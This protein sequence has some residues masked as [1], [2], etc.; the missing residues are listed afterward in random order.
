MASWLVTHA[1]R[2]FDALAVPPEFITQFTAV[3]CNANP[4]HLLI[5]GPSGV[6]KTA[7]WRLVARQVLGVGWRAT[8]HVL[9]ARDLARS[10]GAM[11]KFEDFLRPAGTDSGD[12]LASRTSLEAFDREMFPGSESDI[13]PAGAETEEL[14]LGRKMAP[15]SRLIIIEDADHLGPK[16]QPYLRRMMEQESHTSRFIF[17]ARSPSRLIDALRSRTQFIRLPTTSAE[18]ILAIL[19]QIADKEALQPAP[20]LLGDLAHI[21]AGN[22]RRAIFL[23]EIL[24]LKDRLDDRARLQE[25]MAATTFS[26]TQRVFEDALRGRIH[27]WKWQQVDGRNRRVLHGA[28]G[29][30]DRLLSE[31]ALQPEDVIEQLHT[32]LVSGRLLLPAGASIDLLEALST[33]DIR[34]QRSMHPRIQFEQLFH[35]VA[36]IGR[37]F[38][39]AI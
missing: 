21:A 23:L 13:A 11:G 29:Q 33:C 39:L 4:P 6:G 10:S 34:L 8:T 14:L 17:T 32:F 26:T 38:G 5:A 15:V 12:T 35:E 27:Q 31:H 36:E 7:A 19:E 16:R 28:M 3:A 30:F 1:P 9:Q 18:N 2:R 24:A 20:G 22:L 25:L 37:R